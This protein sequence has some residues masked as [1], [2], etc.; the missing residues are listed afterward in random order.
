[1]NAKNLLGSSGD[2]QSQL[3]ED[4]VCSSLVNFLPTFNLSQTQT[5]IHHENSHCTGEGCSRGK[6]QK[7]W[8]P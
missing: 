5:F 8:L 1:M 4:E 7:L 6:K 2:I 3:T